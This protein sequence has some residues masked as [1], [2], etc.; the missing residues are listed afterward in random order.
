MAAN[1]LIIEF[2]YN[3]SLYGVV[4][5][6]KEYQVAHYINSLLNIDLEKSTDFEVCY[7]RGGNLVFSILIA[8]TESYYIRLIKNKAVEFEKVRK[9]YFFPSLKEYD[10]FLQVE[11]HL[12]D[13]YEEEIINLL[14]G[15]LHIQ[16]VKQLEVENIDHKENLIH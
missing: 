6:L 14:K 3:F 8:E 16:Y 4:C 9:P 15:M 13:W 10:Y 7:I 11:G 5:P 12:H 1:E 2:D